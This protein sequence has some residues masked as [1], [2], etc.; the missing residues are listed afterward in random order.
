ML[1]DLADMHLTKSKN[2]RLRIVGQLKE[3]DIGKLMAEIQMVK[4]CTI[5]TAEVVQDFT[6]IIPCRHHRI[7][8]GIKPMVIKTLAHIHIRISGKLLESYLGGFKDEFFF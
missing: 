6:H 3:I 1:V 8:N 2:L 4:F 7:F 5:L